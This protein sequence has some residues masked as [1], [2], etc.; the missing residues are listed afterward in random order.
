VGGTQLST[1]AASRVPCGVA[2]DSCK[3]P[4]RHQAYAVLHD[5]KAYV[6]GHRTSELNNPGPYAMLLL[7]TL[8]CVRV[9]HSVHSCLHN[10]CVGARDL[11][12][13][14]II[15]ACVFSCS[16]PPAQLLRVRRTPLVREAPRGCRFRATFRRVPPA[17]MFACCGQGVL[18]TTSSGTIVDA[19]AK[20]T[21]LWFRWLGVLAVLVGWLLGW[22]CAVCPCCT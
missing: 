8:V 2:A 10:Y 4:T 6:L 21:L 3:G 11:H 22:H 18:S 5:S 1:A 17:C 9:L 16:Q 13:L 15:E 12:H 20:P 14:C 7:C 19:G